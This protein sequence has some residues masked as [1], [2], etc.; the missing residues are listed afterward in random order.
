[1]NEDDFLKHKREYVARLGIPT[2]PY[3]KE[4]RKLSLISIEY[5]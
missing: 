2:T 1:M 3:K 5:V 4:L